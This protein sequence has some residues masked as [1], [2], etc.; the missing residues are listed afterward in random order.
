MAHA[1]GIVCWDSNA[2]GSDGCSGPSGKGSPVSEGFID[3]GPPPG[4]L[5][6]RPDRGR[7]WFS[8]NGRSGQ[9]FKNNQGFYEFDV[10]IK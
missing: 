4:A 5:I 6:M 3:A 9:A 7:V 8:V 10:E 1:R 2:P